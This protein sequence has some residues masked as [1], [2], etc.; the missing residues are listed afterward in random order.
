M[1]LRDSRQVI[2]LA[3][4]FAFLGNSFLAP[5]SQTER[6][7]LDPEFWRSFPNFNDAELV[8]AAERCIDYAELAGDV[9]SNEE[10]VSRISVEYT[11]LFVGPPRPA[12]APWETFYD[13]VGVS[14]GF[15]EPTFIMQRELA[16]AGLEV[17]NE[18]NQYADHIGIELLLLS[19]LIRRS[20]SSR[21]LAEPLRF[22]YERLMPWVGRFSD[23]VRTEA[24]GGYY[25]GLA[26]LTSSLCKSFADYSQ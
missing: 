19:E 12:V 10:L 1:Q 23:A 7:G 20:A 16:A 17:S 24:Y 6:H 5:M 21:D 11:R 14:S 22:A 25:A 26:T 4:A 8:H 18:N 15:G 2:E 3:D 9:A 13:R